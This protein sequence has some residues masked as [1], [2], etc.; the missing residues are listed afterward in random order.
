MKRVTALMLLAAMIL[1]AASCGGTD[2]PAAGDDTTA[3]FGETT[4][5]GGVL[6]SY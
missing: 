2:T 5:W 6:L 4:E 3:D 1:S